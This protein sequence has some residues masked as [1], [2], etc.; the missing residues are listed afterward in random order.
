MIGLNFILISTIFTIM[1]ILFV[2]LTISMEFPLDINPYIEMG[3][4]QKYGNMI[5]S[6]LYNSALAV[7]II[8]LLLMIGDF[9]SYF[10]SSKISVLQNTI[11]NLDQQTLTNVTNSAKEI[12]N[13][14]FN[15]SMN[16]VTIG[17]FSKYFGWILIFVF[18]TSISIAIIII[19]HYRIKERKSEEQM[20]LE[21]MLSYS[22]ISEPENWAN[23]D[24][25][26]YNISL[27]QQLSNLHEWPVKKIF[28]LDVF[29]SVLL[30]FISH[31][32]S[33]I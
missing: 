25:Y 6:T 7:G 16:I 13:Q 24:R 5:I 32:F 28:I 26:Q 14:S 21:G 33:W 19:L 31:F 30:L 3:N 29:L 23:R 22:S 2:L 11:S 12:I 8:P 9:F 20:R 18:L 27:Y 4:T 15:Q 17:S 10:D 1:I